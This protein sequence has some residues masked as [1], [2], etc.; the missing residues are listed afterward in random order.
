MFGFRYGTRPRKPGPLKSHPPMAAIV[1]AFALV[2]VA[3]GTTYWAVRIGVHDEA[4]PP[5][6][7]SGTRVCLAGLLL[8]AVQAF[9]GR[10]KLHR[11][12]IGC[13]GLA[14]V[15]IFVGGNG[16]IHYAER[17]VPSAVAAVLFATCPLWVGV[18]CQ[19]WPG[20]ER[21]RLRGWAGLLVG[22][23]GVFL[24]LGPQT[25]ARGTLFDWG[26]LLVIGSAACWA[27]GSMIVRHGPKSRHP[28]TSAAYQMIIGGA[29]SSIIGIF[30]GELSQV[31]DRIM[32]G[33]AFAFVYLLIVGSLTGF[34]ALNYLLAH[35]PAAKV[36]TYAY[37]NPAVAMA[38]GWLWG[39]QITGGLIAGIVVILSGVALAGGGGVQQSS[40]WVAHTEKPSRERRAPHPAVRIR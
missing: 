16:L 28:V 6:L 39:E 37:V 21:L 14:G 3:W 22:M 27:L 23:A 11:P 33:A 7:F 38:I 9:R 32:P 10:W 13:A 12:E 19:L 40:T 18:F 1:T 31:P 17:T 35:V 5:A 20:G 30:A 2:Y 26:A 29:A 36:G 34:V 25:D 24:L 8:L 15:V 4:L